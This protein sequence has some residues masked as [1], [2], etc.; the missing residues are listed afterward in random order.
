M[1]ELVG[2][3]ILFRLASLFREKYRGQVEVGLYRDDMLANSYVRRGSALGKQLEK[4]IRAEFT[5]LGL[6]ITIQSN[7]NSVNFL[8]V[9]FNMEAGTFQPFTKENHTPVYVHKESNHPPAVKKA[10]PAGVNKRLNDISSNE[11]M[12]NN[13]KQLYQRALNDAGYDF[14]L[15]YTEKV[16]EEDTNPRKKRQRKRNKL[17]FNPPWSD[18]VQ[19]NVAK[20]FMKTLADSFPADHI[21]H[22]ILNKN[23]VRVSYST[24]KNLARVISSHNSKVAAG[25]GEP[26]SEPSRTCNCP[27]TK[28]GLPNTCPMNGQC[29]T[30]NVIY[31]AT[32]TGTTPRPAPPAAARRAGPRGPGRTPAAPAAAP[33]GGGA[34]EE[35]S[36]SAGGQAAA[37]TSAQWANPGGQGA[38]TLVYGTYTGLASTTFKERFYHHNWNM[39]HDTNKDRTATRLSSL[40]W[41]LKDE[42]TEHS[43]SW[44]ILARAPAFTPV[45]GQCNL[46]NTEKWFIME[47]PGTA[48]ENKKHELFNH[49]RHMDPLLHTPNNNRK[50]K[51]GLG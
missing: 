17:Y 25:A 2:L 46:C 45:T 27:K 39:S 1:L 20:V 23:N 35:R 7:M 16:V 50:R 5:K 11:V 3:L 12:F 49:C 22:P 48:S 30:K 37:A 38:E 14:R 6:N 44:S 51:E 29:L 13:N 8:D 47:R 26:E 19:T 43:V 40:V 42:G 18:T 41:S 28:K 24:T 4:D 21:L 32:V 10:L 36:S 31:C 33:P 34:A 15:E 9:T